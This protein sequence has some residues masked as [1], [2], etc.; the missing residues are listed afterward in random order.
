MDK[1]K[2]NNLARKTSIGS[3]C[4][5]I[6]LLVIW[7]VASESSG[8]KAIALGFIFLL[9]FIFI[10]VPL[11]LISSIS[12]LLERP[13]KPWLILLAIINTVGHLGL[14]HEA[15]FFDNLYTATE[16]KIKEWKDPELTQLRLLIA[17]GPVKD[18]R[19]V[20]EALQNGADPNASYHEKSDLPL[21]HLA[22]AKADLLVIQAL[23]DAGARVDRVAN[24]IFNRFTNPKPIDL[25]L[26]ASTGKPLESMNLL[27]ANGALQSN[28]QLING[29][30]YLGDLELV[31]RF[32]NDNKAVTTDDN[33]NSCL[34]IAVEKRHVKFITE[35]LRIE[36][37]T[38]WLG[39]HLNAH[40]QHGSSPFDLAASK[41]QYEIALQ[42]FQAGG[43]ANRTWTY[44]RILAA[45]N[46]DEYGPHLASLKR[47]V[48]EL[49]ATDD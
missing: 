20:R 42:L 32:K 36:S 26:F 15:G 35:L 27:L 37:N 18:D 17:R 14:A 22:A 31:Q 30:C 43:R 24:T 1:I 45:E 38:E 21:I 25:V 7:L 19:A 40:N 47:L 3:F 23:I 11:W 8:D 13:R 16:N 39:Q 49:T 48:E 46:S 10:S 2:G 41:R 29:A 44:E 12:A 9:A 4:T 34:H 5:W 33:G 6:V 28:S